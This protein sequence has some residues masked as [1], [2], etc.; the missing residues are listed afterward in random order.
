M[1]R[2]GRRSEH[3]DSLNVLKADQRELSFTLSTERPLRKGQTPKQRKQLAKMRREVAALMSRQMDTEARRVFR[4]PISVQMHL[5]LPEGRHDAGLPPVV[6]DYVD[7]LS[8]RVVSD[9][10]RVDHLLILRGPLADQAEVTIRCLPLSIAAAEYDRAFWILGENGAIATV[11]PDLELNQAPFLDGAPNPDL[12]PW[13][14]TPF[15]HHQRENLRRQRGVLSVIADI[16]AQEAEQLEEDPDALVDLDIPPTYDE[17][18]DPQ[19]RDSVRSDFEESVGLALGAELTDQ[20]FDARDRPGG[21]PSWLAE[22]VDLDAADVLQLADEG[23]GCFVLP[24]PT[25]RETPPGE[26]SWP[27]RVE[28]ECSSRLRDPRWARSRFG[29]PLILDIALRG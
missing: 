25:E 20:G 12:P 10:K 13:G 4:G 27:E 3:N 17:F 29:G 15:D 21:Y 8:G 6:K 1:V 16:D 28:H 11:A 19:V 9:D 2:L 24:A 14:L 22:T 5:R 7:L 26:R 23:P 18:H